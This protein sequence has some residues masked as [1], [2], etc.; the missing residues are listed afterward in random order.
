MKVFRTAA[1]AC[2]LAL[3]VLLAGCATGPRISTE[4]DPEADFAR[5]RTFSFYSPLA[6]EREGYTSAASERMKAAA[7]AQM[8]SL[9]YVFT[10]ENPDLWLNINAFTERRTDVST[11]PTVDYAYYYSYRARGY[12]VVP[13]WRDR[14]DVYRYTEGTINIDLVDAARNRLVWE[15]IAVGRVSNTKDAAKRDARIDGAIAD[16]FAKYPYRAGSVPS[17]Q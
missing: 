10:A 4:A 7:R 3:L 16:I 15:G 1:W 12:Y 11:M 17:P 2:G 13:Y 6:I 14:T 9:G 5:Y 8:E